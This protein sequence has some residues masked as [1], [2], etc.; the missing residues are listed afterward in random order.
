MYL[1]I[2]FFIAGAFFRLGQKLIDY[3][4]ENKE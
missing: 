1:L 4:L 3:I 2:I